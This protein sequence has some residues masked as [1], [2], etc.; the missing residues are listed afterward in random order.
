MKKEHGFFPIPTDRMSKEFFDAMQYANKQG[1]EGKEL[2]YA[3]L[4]FEHENFKLVMNCT[5]KIINSP[6]THREEE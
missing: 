6:H 4:S 3:H 5:F 2:E 1:L